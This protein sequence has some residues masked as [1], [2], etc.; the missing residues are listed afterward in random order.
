MKGFYEGLTEEEVSAEVALLVTPEDMPWECEVEVIFQTIENL[1]ASIDAKSGDWYFTGDYPT[2]GGVAVANRAFV[3]WYE[4]KS[5][6]S[7]DL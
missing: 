4:G 6:R 2:P 3:H 7:Y 5:G 1:H